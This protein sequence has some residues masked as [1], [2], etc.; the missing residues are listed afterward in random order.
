MYFHEDTVIYLNGE[1]VRAI[2]SKINLYNQTMHYGNGAFEGIRSYETKNG[3]NLF[4]S[5]EH[6]ERLLYAAE[7][8][9][10]KLHYSIQDLE[11]I[12]YKLLEL[13]KISN[14]Y[15]RPLVFLGKNMSL[16]PT[17][18]VNIVIMAWNWETNN[19]KKLIKVMLST[20]QRPNPKSCIIDAKIVGHYTNSILATT[21]A[22]S[23]G[24]DEALLTDMNG[25]IAQGSGANF[26][27][28]KNN[29]LYTTPIGNILPG[30]TRNIILKMARELGIVV[31]EKLFTYST[32]TTADS[33]FFCGT[34]AEIQGI[35][36]INDYTLPLEWENSIGHLLDQK[37]SNLVRE[38]ENQNILI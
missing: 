38:K 17:P 36:K 3:T 13:N 30:I 5:K 26:F 18:E 21:E 15:V 8:M 11:E 27:Y 32:L 20:Y 22:K 7:K 1:F 6:Y 29:C 33:A 4:K 12:T 25:Y 35:K 34:A 23:Q 31:T 10:I 28:E 24:F 14:G 2:D 37:Y 19:E 16:T 9:H